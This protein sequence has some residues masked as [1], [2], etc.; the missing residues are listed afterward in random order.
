LGG[1]DARPEITKE[2]SMEKEMQQFAQSFKE[3][4]VIHGDVPDGDIKIF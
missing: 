1:A 4:A 3:E 2:Q